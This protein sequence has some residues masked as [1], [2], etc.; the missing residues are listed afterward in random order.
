[1]SRHRLRSL[2]EGPGLRRYF[3]EWTPRGG[4]LKDPMLIGARNAAATAP[5]MEMLAAILGLGALKA[6][7]GLPV[8]LRSRSEALVRGLNEW[9]PG[10]KAQGWK[11]AD[12]KAPEN[13]P[14]WQAIDLLISTRTVGAERPEED[15]WTNWVAEQARGESRIA[16]QEFLNG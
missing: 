8:I 12:R 15:R 9:M 10:W 6:S 2:A 3:A 13:L 5:R 1:M 4:H 16:T 14:E 11:K 7:A